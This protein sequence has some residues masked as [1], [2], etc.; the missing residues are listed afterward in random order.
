MI[1]KDAI[2]NLF[3]SVSSSG[4]QDESDFTRLVL[5]VLGQKGLI[6]GSEKPGWNWALKPIFPGDP[7]FQ[8]LSKLAE[9]R[10]PR[11][12]Y[13]RM[14]DRTLK[15]AKKLYGVQVVP[16]GAGEAPFADPRARP[17]AGRYG[18]KAMAC[19]FGGDLKG[20]D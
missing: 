14:V 17:D 6:S 13:D 10:I 16:A 3:M 5:F 15:E 19:Y 9:R 12:L 11:S 8:G 7:T 18:A 1:H 2:Q 4:T 20:A